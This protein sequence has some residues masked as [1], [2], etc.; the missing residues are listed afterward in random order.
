M[1]FLWLA[2]GMSWSEMMVHYHSLNL[3]ATVIYAEK[4]FL[5]FPFTYHLCNGVRHLVSRA[6]S[7]GHDGR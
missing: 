3:P 5:A 7:E 6:S 4:F 2:S 1:V